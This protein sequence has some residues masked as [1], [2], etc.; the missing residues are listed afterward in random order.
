MI[1]QGEDVKNRPQ[2]TGISALDPEELDGARRL[3]VRVDK[4]KQKSERIR[5]TE[6]QPSQTA[7]KRSRSLELKK[8]STLTVPFK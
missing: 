5:V 1:V 8:L 2:T 4:A 7:A 3:E 6:V